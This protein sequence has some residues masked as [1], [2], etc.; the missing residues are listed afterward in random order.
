MHG[1]IQNPSSVTQPGKDLDVVWN[2][3]VLLKAKVVAVNLTLF[4]LLL[5]DWYKKCISVN[6]RVYRVSFIFFPIFLS[7]LCRLRHL[8][9][10]FKFPVN[11]NEPALINWQLSNNDFIIIDQ[12]SMIPTVIFQ[13]I[14]K[15]LNVLTF[16]AV[17]V[18]CGD[19]GQQQ[20]FTRTT[21]KVMQMNSAFD[22]TSFL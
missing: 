14:L 22:E 3:P 10:S 18:L 7:W 11:E 19:V 5:I 13:L 21:G 1:H 2:K 12:I 17:L 16:R 20:P 4:N 15:V 9:S 8:P 6:R